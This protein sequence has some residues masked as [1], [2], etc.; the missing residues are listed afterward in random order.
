MK[1]KI[2][3]PAL[4]LAALLA[5]SVFAGCNDLP[6]AESP[7]ESASEREALPILS[8]EELNVIR[9]RISSKIEEDDLFVTVKAGGELIDNAHSPYFDWQY[10]HRQY[11]GVTE[12]QT[13]HA[14]DVIDQLSAGMFVNEVHAI[15]GNPHFNSCYIPMSVAA[16]VTANYDYF[17]FYLL[18]TGE[19][20]MLRYNSVF[21]GEY[22]Q[23][24]LERRLPCLAE[25]MRTYGKGRDMRWKKL[26]SA[27]IVSEEDLY[28]MNLQESESVMTDLATQPIFTT[29]EKLE[30]ITLGMT[31][32]EV[33]EI[34][35]C[36]GSDEGLVGEHRMNACNVEGDVDNCY[37]HVWYY[38][39]ETYYMAPET[40]EVWFSVSEQGTPAVVWVS[41]IK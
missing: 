14:H 29:K 9:D 10:Y 36:A 27:Q 37:A 39:D 33:R 24:E 12:N 41:E 31:F 4:F 11:Y 6:P 35:G 19:I 13:Y 25:Y 40:F 22:E 21:V 34:T 20:L 7:S 23:E 1:M 3:I 15:L 16:P 28:R 32:E 17:L 30:R 38:G 8:T 2:K 26:L 18:N 5:L